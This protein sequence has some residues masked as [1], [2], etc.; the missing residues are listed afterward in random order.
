MVEVGMG[1]EDMRD[2]QSKL[3]HLAQNSLAGAARIDHDCLLRH[4]IADDRAIA[5]KG[6]DGKGFS[7][8]CRQHGGMLPSKPIRAQAAALLLVLSETE[9]S[10]RP[11]YRTMSNFVLDDDTIRGI[12]LRYRRDEGFDIQQRMIIAGVSR[13]TRKSQ[14]IQ[15]PAALEPASSQLP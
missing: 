8:H 7:Y 5:T 9:W 13:H 1:V 6:W 2:R 12:P 10:K 4:R 3:L 11:P 15:E 14:T